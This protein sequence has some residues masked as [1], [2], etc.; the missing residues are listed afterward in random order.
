VIPVGGRWE[1][2]LILV[3]RRGSELVTT[4]HGGCVFVPLRGAGGWA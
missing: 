2:E 1:Q 3:E 4:N